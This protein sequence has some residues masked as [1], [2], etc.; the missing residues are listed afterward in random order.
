MKGG[1]CR[2]PC[3]V[4]GPG[5]E[6][7]PAPPLRLA[8]RPAPLR[9]RP[10]LSWIRYERVT[11]GEAR[12]SQR[13][14]PRP[15]GYLSFSWVMVERLGLMP[16]TIPRGFNNCRLKFFNSGDIPLSSSDSADPD[17]CGNRWLRSCLIRPPAIF[18]GPSGTTTQPRSRGDESSLIQTGETALNVLSH[19]RVSAAKAPD[20][21]A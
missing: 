17:G 6:P 11:G 4:V 21:T 20:T 10:N 8:G 2:P 19:T 15:G 9:N 1:R 16:P 14:R 7:A 12:R 5:Q 3:G 18:S 13:K